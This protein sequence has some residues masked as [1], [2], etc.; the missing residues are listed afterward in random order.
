MREAIKLLHTEWSRGWGGQELRILADCEG[1]LKKGYQVTLGCKPGSPIL[2]VAGS[3]GIPT[4]T[5]PFLAP[6]DVKTIFLI[7]CYLRRNRVDL[8]QTHSSIDSWTASIA[9]RL[10]GIPV[11]RSRHIS[12]EIK[13]SFF[14]KLLYM[15]LADRVIT[16]GEAIKDRMVKVNGYKADKI[17][18]IPTGVDAALFRPDIDPRPIREEFNLSEDSHVL[19]IVAIMRGAKGHEFLF[20]AV[21]LLGHEIPN[22]KV[23][24]VGDG[25][26]R[27]YVEGHA[28]RL[29]VTDKVI[30][31]GFREDTPELMA[32]MDQFVLPSINEGLPQVVLQ[33]MLVGVSVVAS[34]AG[35]ITEVV[36]P[37]RTGLL[38]PP[39]NPAALKEAILANYHNPEKAKA[40]ARAARE[41]VLQTGTLEVMINKTEAVYQE[42]LG[43]R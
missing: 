21:K 12:A 32:A 8:V 24:V 28:R 3:K 31:T 27:D 13:E 11:I 14:S 1:F 30:F 38:V 29:K 25:P 43:R 41:K 5:F 7:A 6:L 23:L 19:G 10:V 37:N 16:S 35:G 4:V 39:K 20:E 22:L 33:A 2:K 42:V 15:R 18:S 17:V 26:S 9:A 36:Q 40:M 34:A